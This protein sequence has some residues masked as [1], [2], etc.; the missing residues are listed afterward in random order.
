MIKLRILLV[1]RH[2]P[3]GA[4]GASRSP[5]S[6][7]RRARRARCALSTGRLVAGA[8]LTLAALLPAC[9]SPKPAP[10]PADSRPATADSTPVAVA[11]Q[12]VSGTAP[13]ASASAPAPPSAAES[14][15]ATALRT[16]V[17]LIGVDGMEWSVV[18]PL[19]AQ[20]KLPAIRRL[21][22]R[23]TYGYLTTIDPTFSPV[24]WTSIATG[25][26]PAKHGIENFVYTVSVGGK[27]EPRVY[28]SGMRK[29]K[30]FWNI[31]SDQGRTVDCI[32]WWITYPAEPIHGVMVSQ[33]N[34]T[35]AARD[36]AKAIWKG[37]LLKGVEGQVSP[38]ARQ[39]AVMATLDAVD[40]ALPAITRQIFGAF[41]H[42]LDP[43]GR[44]LWD[45]TQWAFR[46]D[47]TYVRVAKD[48]LAQREPFDVFAVYIGGPDV[49][50]HRFWQYAHPG[51]FAHPPDR[52]QIENF[53]KII[54]DYYVYT[55]RVIGELLATQRPDVDVIVLSDHGFHAINQTRTFSA[56]DSPFDRNSGNHLDGPPGVLI[57]AGRDIL[58]AHAGSGAQR[59]A[60]PVLGSVL[61][62]TPTLLAL[63][64][65]AVGRD[66]DGSP[67]KT[68]IR[69][70][71]LAA[72]PITFVE[73][74]DTESWIAQRASRKEASDDDAE[75][76]EQL[77][78]LG[79]IH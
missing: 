30:A 34:T 54:D 46:A 79:Y 37:T 47:A 12:P 72:A 71:R 57:A 70:E 8:I 39:A 5:R 51:E 74:H 22:D 78:S 32:G 36:S 13:A 11:E 41:R 45:E 76:L 10:A 61:D 15:P 69:P 20:G 18:E 33:T 44:L 29:T 56:Q 19:L 60:R 16:P 3:Q 62:V 28:T 73:T 23:G 75:R 53:G 50:S 6:L 2:L 49:V 59:S 31:L 17:L 64:G 63:Q 40:K 58:R 42:P 68:I 65:I 52:D 43:F 7:P 4:P 38:P 26:V 67:M 24:I 66:M 1:I 21:M 27:E 35:A 9:S 55:D 77:R 14:A 25:K 48:L